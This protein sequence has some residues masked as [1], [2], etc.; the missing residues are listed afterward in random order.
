M[1]ELDLTKHVIDELQTAYESLAHSRH[2]QPPQWL[3]EERQFRHSR[4]NDCLFV[5]LKGVR[6]VSLLNAS[7]VLLDTGYVHEMGILCRCM[8]ETLEDI[9]LFMKG[10]GPDGQLSGAQQKVFADFFLEQFVEQ[11]ASLP[12][13]VT[14]DRVPR[15]KV[16]AAIA[17]VPESPVNPHD[18]GHILGTIDSVYSGYVHGAYPQIM[19]LCGGLRPGFMMAGMNGTSRIEVWQGQL[20]MYAY[21]AVLGTIVVAKR[22][23]EEDLAEHLIGLRNEIERFREVVPKIRTV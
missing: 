18:H 20:L 13:A 16:R 4:L 23:E 21:R 8:D 2:I 6:W 19:E 1:N 9:M 15:R 7:V 14:R 10:L 5:Y 3:P 17:G 22:L 12:A 11:E